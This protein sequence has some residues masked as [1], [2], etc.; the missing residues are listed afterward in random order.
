MK[1]FLSNLFLFV[2]F[3][4]FFVDICFN[5]IFIDNYVSN[6]RILQYIMIIRLDRLLYIIGWLLYLRYVEG[7]YLNMVLYRELGQNFEIFVVYICNY[8]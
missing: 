8:L 2:N 7:V 6:C 5:D 1:N 4:F 3:G